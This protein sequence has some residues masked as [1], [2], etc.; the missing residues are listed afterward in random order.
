MERQSFNL[1]WIFQKGGGTALDSVTAPLN[2]AVPVVLPHDAMILNERQRDHL[3]K[4]CGIFSY[5][6]VHY[7][8][9]FNLKTSVYLEFEGVYEFSVFVNDCRPAYQW[10][11]PF[12][13]T[14][15]PLFA[16]A[17]SE[18]DREK[19]RPQLPVVYRHRNLPGC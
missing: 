14:F 8:K 9:T 17:Q 11:P 3:R 16:S 10:L 13:W 4:L 15:P 12:C 19:R 1:G 7:T 18:G 6:T 5:Y 2:T